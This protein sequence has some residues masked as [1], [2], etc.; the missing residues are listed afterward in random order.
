MNAIDPTNLSSGR[1]P[2]QLDPTG[3]D[4][5][6]EGAALRALG[7]AAPVEL[8]GGIIAWGV[9]DPGLIR[10]LLTHRD[11]SKDMRAHWPGYQDL[12]ADWPLRPW[13]DVTNMLTAYGTEH[14]RLRKLVAGAFTQRRIMALAPVIT[15]ITDRL[16]DQLIVASHGGENSGGK[17][18][19]PVDLRAHFAYPLPLEVICYLFGVPADDEPGGAGIRD[20][21]RMTVEKMFR[22][23]ISADEATANTAEL[24]AIL[25]DLIALKCDSPGDDLTSDLIAAR[26]VDETLTEQELIDT[27]L[28]FI[29]A[30]HETTVNLITNGM[31]TLLRHPEVLDR[32]RRRDEPDLAARVV[33]ELLRYEPPVQF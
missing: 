29:G 14:T 6:S 4:I 5:H 3:Y 21:M 1:C 7:P 20:G 2:Y 33:E 24:Y 12:P 26:D 19:R 11:I 23:D 28:L 22:T 10:R 32:L 16:L 30:G 17:R 13:V 15:A 27:L 18:M 8:P 25:T 31:L 9:T